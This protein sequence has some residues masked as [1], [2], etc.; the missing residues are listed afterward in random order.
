MTKKQ[1]ELVQGS[2][3]LSVT[4]ATD[5]AISRL[6]ESIDVKKVFL[7][8]IAYSVRLIEIEA[9]HLRFPRDYAI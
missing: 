1:R 5:G 3:G 4:P 6:Q 2:I 9:V 8:V 7:E